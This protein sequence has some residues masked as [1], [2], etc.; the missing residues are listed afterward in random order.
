MAPRL[1]S[2]TTKDLD[3]LTL[4]VPNLVLMA[5]FYVYSILAVASC[6]NETVG[7]AQGYQQDPVLRE[8]RDGLWSA[9]TEPHS[10][11]CSLVMC[12]LRSQQ[13]CPVFAATGPFSR[14][15]CVA[16]WI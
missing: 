8:A 6:R 16:F 15:H 7:A 13:L 2:P 5:F 4:S 12:S 1:Y 9:N 11:N 10:G 14:A 3:T